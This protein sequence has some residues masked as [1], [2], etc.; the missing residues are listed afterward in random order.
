MKKIYLLFFALVLVSFALSAY[1]YPALPEQ[2]ASHWGMNGEPDDYMGKFWGAY[3][4][5][6]FL[7]ILVLLFIVI[8]YIDPLKKNIKKFINYYYGFVILFL[9]F[10]LAV[11]F[12]VILWNIGIKVRPNIV[13]P[14]GIGVLFYY[15][16]IL[17]NHAKQNWFIG[18]R[19]PWTL[20]N[21]KVWNRTHQ[22][23]ARLFKLSGAIAVVGAFFP[24]YSFYLIIAP[25]LIAALY[26]V[27][28]SYFLYQKLA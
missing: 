1:Y 19:T 4:M 25:V 23:G 27:V 28:Y 20:S 8:P 3:L 26:P 17:C 10:M 21:T 13:F 11:H 7:L 22:L 5:P 15:I 24:Q 16:G 12:F 14:I 9:L 18:I 2:M 6:I